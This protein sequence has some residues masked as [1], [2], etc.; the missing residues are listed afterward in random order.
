MSKIWSPYN[1][2][3]YTVKLDDSTIAGIGSLDV[4]DGRPGLWNM[5]WLHSARV[6]E[7]LEWVDDPMFAPHFSQSVY[8]CEQSAEV[9]CGAKTLETHAEELWPDKWIR[10]MIDRDVQFPVRAFWDDCEHPLNSWL[11]IVTERAKLSRY[12]TH[13]EGNKI[14]VNF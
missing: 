1:R 14:I 4:F 5:V 13:R 9:L 11:Q 10:L 3:M 6:D 7:L 2:E 12:H 8:E